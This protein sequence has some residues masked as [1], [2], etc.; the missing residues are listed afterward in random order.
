M[1]VV[2]K[3]DPSQSVAQRDAFTR[4]ATARFRKVWQAVVKFV[5]AD[6]ELGLAPRPAINARR[7]ALLSDPDKVEAFRRF[8]AD[9]LREHILTAAPDSADAWT[10]FYVTAAYKAAAARAYRELKADL[11]AEPD[12]IFGPLSRSFVRGVLGDPRANQTLKSIRRRVAA[13]FDRMVDQ[14]DGLAES[15]MQDAIAQGLRPKAAAQKVNAE[16]LDWGRKKA[17]LYA[18]QAVVYASAEGKLDG[19]EG[20]GVD[21]VELVA[22]WVYQAKA[23]PRCRAKARKGPY[24]ISKIRGLIPFH[25][26]CR[27]TWRVVPKPERRR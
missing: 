15:V 6:D 21:E 4:E 9:Q 25:A 10:A 22:E 3:S 13:D 5:V 11:R 23:C 8:F 16:L 19:Y 7:Y 1:P 27:C 20:G 2:T 26:W 12:E 24:K 14:M 17:K 18:H